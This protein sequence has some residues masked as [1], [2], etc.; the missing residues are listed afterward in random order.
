MRHAIL[1][2]GGVGLALGAALTRAGHPV[3]LVMRES[4]RAAYSGT[5][6]VHSRLKGGSAVP[7]PAVDRLDEDVDALWLT[8]KA[9]ALESALRRIGP[10]VATASVIPLLN[11]IDHLDLL[12]ARFGPRVL[13][14]AIRIEAERGAPGEVTWNSLFGSVELAGANEALRADLYSAGID[15]ELAADPAKVLWHKLIL[16]LPLALATTVAEGPLGVV[17]RDRELTSL[18]VGAA[19]EVCAVAAAHGVPVDAAA[20]VRALESLPGRTN[21][22]L[23][24]DVAAGVRP[25]E[26]DTIA[27]PVLRH[28]TAPSVAELVR[29]ARAA[30]A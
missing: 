17:R 6:T 9:P 2:A 22:S 23:R 24:R 3:T 19:R 7:V 4:S 11:G 27:G 14:G 28:G 29:L 15:C 18:M 10:A 5:I 21:S 26:L 12:R 25:T 16:L 30:G 13:A 20:S 1:G 8:V